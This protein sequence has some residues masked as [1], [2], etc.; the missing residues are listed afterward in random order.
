MF[1][2]MKQL[3]AAV[4]LATV[5][6]SATPQAQAKPAPG[7]YAEVNGLKMYYEVHGRK[8]GQTP[9]LV[10]LHGAFGTIDNCF[11]KVIPQLAKQRQVIG[12]EL[13]G[14]G[15]TADID[16][17]LRYEQLADDVAALL[18][19]INVAS[20]DVYRY[21]MGGGVALQVA[22]RHPAV[23]RKLVVASA[24]FDMSGW[25]PGLLD[26]IKGM[27]P[28]HLAGSPWAKDYARVAPQP[29]NW[30]ALIEKVKELDS[31]PQHWPAKDI[32]GIKAPTL[33]IAGDSDA[34]TVEHAAQIYRLRGGG[35]MGDMA[36]L[37]DS[38]LAILPGTHHV[39]VLEQV[40]LQAAI[41]P[42]FLD[43]TR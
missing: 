34:I 8:A 23:V 20:A 39:G 24:A 4:T 1:Q 27:K 11:G 38:Q 5:A 42:A 18:K 36:G 9:P 28:E 26:M 15:R 37:P 16:R 7:K 14:H 13:Q 12:V 10:L 41:I 30:N 31:R 32:Q 33:M 6:L 35:A 25:Q 17:P 29:S 19:Q 21:S 43:A 2:T 3:L 40:Q 22:V